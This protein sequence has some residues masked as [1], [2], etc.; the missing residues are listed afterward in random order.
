M[1]EYSKA[2]KQFRKYIKEWGELMSDYIKREEATSVPVVPK[3]HRKHFNSLD[4]AFE[5]GWN[6][7]LACVNMIPSADV[8]EVVRCKDCKHWS[9]Y[10]EGIGVCDKLKTDTGEGVFCSYGESKDGSGNTKG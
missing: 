9:E 2:L 4:D 10:M 5:T 6:E 8:V 3:E 7:A 1:S